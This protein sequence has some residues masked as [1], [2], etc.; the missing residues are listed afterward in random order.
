MALELQ[1]R[2]NPVCWGAMKWG[3]MDGTM[4]S[5]GG[6]LLRIQCDWREGEYKLWHTRPVRVQVKWDTS[7]SLRIKI[8]AR[9]LLKVPHFYHIFITS[10]I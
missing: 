9:T 4:G 8:N 10:F 5:H 7:Q 6:L 2:I 3:N 1:C